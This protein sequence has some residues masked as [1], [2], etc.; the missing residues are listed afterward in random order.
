MNDKT[1]LSIETQIDALKLAAEQANSRP[2]EFILVGRGGGFVQQFTN[3]LVTEQGKTYVEHFAFDEFS[4]Q[5]YNYHISPVLLHE[6][7]IEYERLLNYA[8]QIDFLNA[9]A[10]PVNS[11]LFN[12]TEVDHSGIGTRQVLW[13]KTPTGDP[14]TDLEVFDREIRK[15]LAATFRQEHGG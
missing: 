7:T 9:D 3:F 6:N 12:I 4:G 14:E 8:K 2:A 5:P 11:T 1:E 10:P 13:N 15:F